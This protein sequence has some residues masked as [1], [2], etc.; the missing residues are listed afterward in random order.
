MMPGPTCSKSPAEQM[1]EMLEYLKDTCFDSWSKRVWLDIEGPQYWLGDYSK[2][3]EYYKV[4]NKS[5]FL[6]LLF[7]FFSLFFCFHSNWWTLV[8]FITFPVVFM[9]L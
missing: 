1:N 5:L 6:A 7:L 3:Q 4:A 2:N 8:P 9:V